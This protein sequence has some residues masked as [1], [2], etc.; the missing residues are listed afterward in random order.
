VA[1]PDLR[2]LAARVVDRRL[3]L[4]LSIKRAAERAEISLGTWKRVERGEAVR[5]LTYDKVEV[6][7]GWTVGSC[8]K[9]MDG[10]EAVPLDDDRTDGVSIQPVPPDVLE[11][12]IRGAV[13][14][15]M[16]AGTD[17]NASKIREINERAIAVLRERGILPPS[18]D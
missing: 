9:I 1:S 17:L 13:Q 15:A 4:N 6:A 18:A 11:G 16:V 2:R 5:H 3:R 8:R 12:E 10:G 7:L 14:G